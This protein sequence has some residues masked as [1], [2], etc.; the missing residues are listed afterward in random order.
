MCVEISPEG[1]KTCDVTFITAAKKARG[2]F[3]MYPE[4]L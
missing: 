3:K 1:Q 2:S 4:S